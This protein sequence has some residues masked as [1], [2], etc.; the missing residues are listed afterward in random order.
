MLKA[1]ELDLY[2]I[3]LKAFETIISFIFED[4]VSVGIQYFYFE[5]YQFLN[6]TFA[7]IKAGFM[8]MKLLELT[9]R[10]TIRLEN[11]RKKNFEN[12]IQDSFYRFIQESF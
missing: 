1:F 11:S 7:N 10:V 9:I 6:D 2:F 3:T 5:K 4:F 12:S 8:I